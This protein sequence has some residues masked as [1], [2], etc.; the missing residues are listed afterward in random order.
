[1]FLHVWQAIDHTV[2]LTLGYFRYFFPLSTDEYL[3]QTVLDCKVIDPQAITSSYQCKVKIS[4]WELNYILRFKLEIGIKFI[5]NLVVLCSSSWADQV[6]LGEGLSFCLPFFEFI[7]DI[8][9]MYTHPLKP[10]I[11]YTMILYRRGYLYSPIQTWRYIINEWNE[12]E[13]KNRQT[14]FYLF[15]NLSAKQKEVKPYI[16][17]LYN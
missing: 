12:N 4:Y 14:M 10:I 9:R 11:N 15:F 5:I 16:Q 7:L 8:I 2:L 6:K 17:A 13:E 1:M 3:P